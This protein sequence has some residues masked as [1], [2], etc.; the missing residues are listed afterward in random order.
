M[1]YQRWDN[2]IHRQTSHLHL[3]TQK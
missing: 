3:P 2:Q 1:S